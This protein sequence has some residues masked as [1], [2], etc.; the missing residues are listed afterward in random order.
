MLRCSEGPTWMGGTGGAL[1][2]AAIPS[3]P[4]PRP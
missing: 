3:L 2:P 4:Q 1:V